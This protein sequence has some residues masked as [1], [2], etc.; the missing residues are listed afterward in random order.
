MSST[1]YIRESV[2]H[3]LQLTTAQLAQIHGLREELK[4]DRTFWKN[5]QDRDSESDFEEPTVHG[6]AIEVEEV[7]DG[8][9]YLT[10][11]NAV[12]ILA[13]QDLTLVVTPK[14]SADHFNF[15]ATK[16]LGLRTR[17]SR[18]AGNMA[19]GAHFHE[20]F[21]DWFLNEVES[22]VRFGLD[23]DYQEHSASTRYLRGRINLLRSTRNLLVGRFD[24]D[25]RFETF[26]ED[27]SVNRVIKSALNAVVNCPEISVNTRAR[28]TRALGEFRGI[29]T[30]T[31]E[32]FLISPRAIPRA[33]LEA[34]S[35]SLQVLRGLGRALDSGREIARSFLLPTPALIEAGIRQI[36]KEG[37][38][39]ALV[40][41]R[42]MQ[43][44]SSGHFKVNPDLLLGESPFTGDVKYKVSD[45]TWSRNDLAQ[46]VM[47][48]A[49]FR[50]K[51][52][53]VIN[54][55]PKLVKDP[56]WV[57]FGDIEIQNVSW[58][59]SED[60]DPQRSSELLISTFKT[61]LDKRDFKGIGVVG[62]SDR[63]VAGVVTNLSHG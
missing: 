33:S 21:A 51:L 13:L 48:A 52:G 16:A 5:L 14:I 61:E 42:S 57:S 15:I 58:N 31:R 27:N 30:P 7:G 46:G 40:E 11:K 50:A 24:F 9:V 28:A 47:F 53:F 23:R 43:I 22:L 59:C 60:A 63:F 6:R 41:K 29:G 45:G 55:A 18:R 3:R 25:S 1:T 26:D 12:G 49:A 17:T 36:L 8:F 4:S 39:P 56:A 32:D 2:R 37:L 38:A 35:L 34:F 62:S 10:V 19:R 54:F 44:P 20:I